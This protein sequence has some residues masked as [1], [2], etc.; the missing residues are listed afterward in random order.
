M[1][2]KMTIFDYLSQVF[3]IFGVTT[4]LLI[5]FCLLFGESAQGYSSIF[6]LG[7]AGLSTGTI[8]EFLGAIT[9]IIGLRWL[10]LTDTL[11]RRMPLFL[12]IVLLFASAFS[13]ILGFIFVCGWFPASEP[14]AWVMFLLCFA[15]SCGISTGISV[16]HERMENK[17]LADA[18]Q[19]LKEEP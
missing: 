14:T 7:S 9:C 3:M 19:K 1:E 12:R 11:I 10:F 6:R 18:L 17:K 5:G 13:V 16:L 8:L 2:K 15:V 4:A